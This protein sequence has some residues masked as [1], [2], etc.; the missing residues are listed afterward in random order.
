MEPVPEH[1][2]QVRSQAQAMD[3]SLV[4]LSQG[5]ESV[6]DGSPEGGW[7]LEVL[8]GEHARALAT[9]RL[10]EFENRR[11]P[12]RRELLESGLLFD[13]MA[14]AWVLLLAV[15]YWL[16]ANKNLH[17]T[18]EMLPSAVSRGEWWRLFTATWL[19][20][21][22]GHWASNAAFGFVLLGLSMARYGTGVGLLASYVAGVG[23]NL[24]R[25]AVSRNGNPSLGASGM[26]MG[27]L[28]LLAI[29]SV[30]LWRHHPASRKY[31][32]SGTCG[33]ILLFVLLGTAPG[34]DL[35]AHFG[36]FV[37]GLALGTLAAALANLQPRPLLNLLC[38]IAT[39]LLVIYPW[40]LALR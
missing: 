4:L 11:Y 23:G 35:L 30:P 2:I 17:S 19:H 3:W 31:I 21:D 28:G 24:L 7:T 15:F 38:A 40:W 37:S 16:D 13:W 25:F 39:A 1:R 34:T 5:I 8:P 18:G 29:Q 12:W 26:V 32:L 9:L 27:M 6:L 36:G 33:G 22:L 14:L 20:A 10:Y